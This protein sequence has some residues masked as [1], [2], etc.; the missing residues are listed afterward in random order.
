MTRLLAGAP[1]PAAASA[2]PDEITTIRAS[3]L[4][5]AAWYLEHHP[6]VQRAG[7]DPLRHY[8]QQG[9][10]A[11]YRPNPY[12]DPAWYREQNPEL[13]RGDTDPLLHYIRIGEREHRR[14]VPH[15]DPAWYRTAYAV[16]E[17][18]SALRHFLQ[19]RHGG[20]VSPIPEFDAA[21]YLQTY[22]DVAAAGIDPVE[23]Y[24]IQGYKEARN[25]SPRFDTRFYRQRYLNGDTGVNPLLH[26]LRNR[27]SGELHTCLPE[28]EITI[29]REVRRFSQPGPD[30]ESPRPLPESAPRRACVLAY[31]LP[32][33]HA[34]AENDA[35]WGRG[36]TE[37]T[38]LPRGLPRFAGHY[39]P[40]IPRDLGHYS[41]DDTAV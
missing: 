25:P 19:R 41:L 15:F 7:G 16:A 5:D 23:H 34:C 1:P 10:R 24:M 30:F 13:R 26:Y 36:F 28:H 11:G 9:W 29:P 39:Q 2:E 3:G 31:Y 18:E 40:R 20:E 35:W 33:F 37:W 21:W 6:D 27:G 4:F 8:H 12:F 22:R 32:Q 38:N 17:G 14:P